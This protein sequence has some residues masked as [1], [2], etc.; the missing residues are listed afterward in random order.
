MLLD[1]D[2]KHDSN[3]I[4]WLP[5]NLQS[6]FVMLSL[7]IRYC[8]PVHHHQV[9]QAENFGTVENS[10]HASPNFFIVLRT[11]PQLIECVCSGDCV[12]GVGDAA[13][14]HPKAPQDD[15]SIWC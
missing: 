6:D 12:V 11:F 9:G 13:A 1:Q 4:C 2:T 5:L 10:A 14:A 8:S 3:D 7:W 15:Y